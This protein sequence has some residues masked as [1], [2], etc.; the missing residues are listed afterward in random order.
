MEIETFRKD[1][2]PCRNRLHSNTQTR[3]LGSGHMADQTGQLEWQERVEH[4]P[5]DSAA[6]ARRREAL[7]SPSIVTSRAP[8]HAEEKTSQLTVQIDQTSRC[9][10]S[11]KERPV[12]PGELGRQPSLRDRPRDLTHPTTATATITTTTPPRR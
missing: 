4:R 11:D 3:L 7:G 12:S 1:R 6:G 5:A 2:F 8:V 10:P 9:W